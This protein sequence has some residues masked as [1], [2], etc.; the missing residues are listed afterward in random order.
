MLNSMFSLNEAID[1]LFFKKIFELIFF[2]H[3]SEQEFWK[4]SSQLIVSWEEK[5]EEVIR[6]YN[7]PS[8]MAIFMFDIK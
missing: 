7:F 2:F 4:F 3:E 5:G 1:G 6:D 8:L